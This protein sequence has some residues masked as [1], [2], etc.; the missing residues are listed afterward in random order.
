M[1]QQTFKRANNYGNIKK[2]MLSTYE[3]NGKKVYWVAYFKNPDDLS[4]ADG[5]EFA[6]RKDAMYSIDCHLA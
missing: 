1:K 2:A 6:K 5:A 3:R 4:A